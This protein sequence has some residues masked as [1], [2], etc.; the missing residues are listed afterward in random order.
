VQPEL[1]MSNEPVI[2]KLANWLDS[3]GFRINKQQCAKGKYNLIATLGDGSDG[4]ILS[5]HTDTVPM[6]EKLWQSDPFKLT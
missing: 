2:D 5:G 4:L 1:D 6:D 3:S